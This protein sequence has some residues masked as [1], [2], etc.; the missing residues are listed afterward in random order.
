LPRR[1]AE[2][3]DGPRC[4]IS[5]APVSDTGSPSRDH[6]VGSGAPDPT[7]WSRQ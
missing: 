3:E 5:S 2:R 1:R 6:V 4:I 7:A